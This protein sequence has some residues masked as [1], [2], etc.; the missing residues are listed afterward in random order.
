[1]EQPCYSYCPIS[2]HITHKCN[3]FITEFNKYIQLRNEESKIGN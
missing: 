1:M 3:N 2:V